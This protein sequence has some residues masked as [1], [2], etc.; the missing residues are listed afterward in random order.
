MKVKVNWKEREEVENF[1][2]LVELINAGWGMGKEV[3]H[4]L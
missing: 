4:K 3:T 2:Y 1:K